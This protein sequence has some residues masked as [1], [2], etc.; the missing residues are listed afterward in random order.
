MNFLQVLNELENIPIRGLDKPAPKP[1]EEPDHVPDAGLKFNVADFTIKKGVIA[2]NTDEELDRKT[3]KFVTNFEH[4]MGMVYNYS[5]DD[6]DKKAYVMYY[7]QNV[8]H[9]EGKYRS[10]LKKNIEEQAKDDSKEETPKHESGNLRTNIQK[11]IQALS[12]SSLK[13]LDNYVKILQRKDS[14]R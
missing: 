5:Q 9:Y 3:D 2:A 7:D 8:S 11:A 6:K 12:D 1:V 4:R 10:A 14:Y 13:D